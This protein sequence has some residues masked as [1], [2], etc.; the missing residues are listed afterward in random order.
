MNKLLYFKSIYFMFF[1]NKL[2][3]SDKNISFMPM[4]IFVP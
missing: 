4:I 3:F 1:S 2:L